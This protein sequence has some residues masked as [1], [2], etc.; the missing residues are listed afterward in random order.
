MLPMASTSEGMIAQSTPMLRFLSE[1]QP[2]T[3]DVLPIHAH[4]CSA[5]IDLRY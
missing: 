1:F 3:V 5:S 4:C 2:R